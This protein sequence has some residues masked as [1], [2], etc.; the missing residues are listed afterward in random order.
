[1]VVFSLLLLC[2]VNS[3]ELFTIH[4]D[5][6]SDSIISYDTITSSTDQH[7]VTQLSSDWD[8]SFG[9]AICNDT[10]YAFVT[11]DTKQAVFSF[12]IISQK[13][14][15]YILPARQNNFDVTY[16]GMTLQCTSISNVLLAAESH[17]YEEYGT[18]YYNHVLD[19]LTFRD[20]SVDLDVLGSFNEGYEWDTL[21]KFAFDISANEVWGTFQED[22]IL[23]ILDTNNGKYKQGHS[24]EKNSDIPYFVIPQTLV[25][26][27]FKG[28][29]ME[30]KTNN[31]N[32]VNITKSAKQYDLT[33][34]LDVNVD[35]QDAYY[36]ESVDGSMTVCGGTAYVILRNDTS[37]SIGSFDIFTGKQTNVYRLDSKYQNI[38]S[39]ACK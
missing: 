29:M 1:M 33:G 25:G 20:S 37:P 26:R 6:P 12:N 22:K 18:T 13:Y 2:I 19:K 15:S 35:I 9:G 21:P 32:F 11:K 23:K 10:Y 17:T 28:S 3:V 5:T 24:W 39:V 16:I 34:D 8:V 27:S 7:I 36:L 30:N 14:S 4:I 31:V 38:H